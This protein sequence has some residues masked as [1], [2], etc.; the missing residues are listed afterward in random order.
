MIQSNRHRIALKKIQKHHQIESRWNK[1]RK[2]IERHRRSIENSSIMHRKH[3]HL[4]TSVQT[5]KGLNTN[6]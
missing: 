1:H 4:S 6:R 2:R 3:I 5:K